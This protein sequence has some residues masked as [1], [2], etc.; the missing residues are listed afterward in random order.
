MQAWAACRAAPSSRA[1]KCKASPLPGDGSRCLAMAPHGWSWLPFTRGSLPAAWGRLRVVGA[2]SL[3]PEAGSG[4]LR[5][6]SPLPGGGSPRLE[7]AP[8][9]LGLAPCSLGSAPVTH[10]RGPRWAPAKAPSLAAPASEAKPQLEVTSLRVLQ[11]TRGASQP[12][13]GRGRGRAFPSPAAAAGSIPARGTGGRRERRGER[14]RSR[15]V[16]SLYLLLSASCPAAGCAAPSAARCPSS[17]AAR[18]AQVVR[19]PPPPGR[20]PPAPASPAAGPAAPPRRA[21]RGGAAGPGRAGPSRAAS[22]RTAPHRA[23]PSPPHPPPARPLGARPPPRRGRR[24]GA[25]WRL[26]LGADGGS[27]AGR[28]VRGWAAPRGM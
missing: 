9:C 15:P 28:G 12:R 19:A 21:E 8:H 3:L 16:P 22:H 2:G 5:E 14:V 13:G 7:L 27:G 25:Q 4:L 11:A 1:S 26:L 10:T 23:P 20:S 17:A 6:S 24:A 18:P